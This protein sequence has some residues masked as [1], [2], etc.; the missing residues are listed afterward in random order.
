M[1]HAINGIKFMMSHAKNSR[2]I[3]FG[4]LCMICLCMTNLGDADAKNSPSVMVAKCPILNYHV[5]VDV[6]L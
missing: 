6:I 1:L 2:C 5:L 3:S 4:C